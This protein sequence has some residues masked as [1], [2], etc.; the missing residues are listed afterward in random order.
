[1]NNKKNILILGGYGYGNTGDE[2][3]LN[4]TLNIMNSHFHDYNILVLT[5]NLEYTRNT[6]N[7][8]VDYAPREAFFNSQSDP[9]T[10]YWIRNIDE[11]KQMKQKMKNIYFKSWLKKFF[12]LRIK[13]EKIDHLIE[14]LKS[15]SLVYYSGG[16]YL[17]G[18]TLSRLFDGC[19]FIHICKLFN[20]SVVLSGQTIGLFRNDFD[21]K[22]AK[23][24]FN[25]AKLITLRDPIDSANA[26]EEIGIKNYEVMFDDALFCEKEENINI[27]NELLK[28]AGIENKEKY[29]TFHM[30]YWGINSEE[31]KKI[32]INKLKLIIEHTQEIFKNIPILLIPMTPSDYDQ[33]KEFLQYIKKENTYLLEYDYDFKKIRS[34][35]SNSIL[36]I[37]M[38]HHPIIF[39]VGEK[40][41]VISTSYSSYYKHKNRGALKI[42]GLEKYNIE[43]EDNNYEKNFY[44]R[45]ID[46]KE[47]YKQNIKYLEELF[48]SLKNKKEI[49]I[50]KVK[51]YL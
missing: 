8:N 50:N 16:G 51:E 10:I 7:C 35:I 30:H 37:T 33:Q 44:D 46:I 27:I 4:E 5:P 17:T 24:A 18:A 45:I 38:K 20:V 26:L 40:T 31:E 12:N 34:I 13:N 47:N 49:F 19:L 41:P 32:I 28:N 9:N 22:M 36:C 43:L 23:K 2:A 39:A 42:F 21:K 48:I 6:H 11:E 3:Q 15:T 1:M 14:L 25:Y 29:I